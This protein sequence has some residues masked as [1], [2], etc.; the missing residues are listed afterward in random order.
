MKTVWYI[1]ILDNQKKMTTNT[2][3]TQLVRVNNSYCIR[4]KT[5]HF[6]PKIHRTLIL[7]LDYS[8]S[9]IGEPLRCGRQAMAAV[10][11]KVVDEFDDIILIM[12]NNNVTEFVVTKTNVEEVSH[13]VENWQASG[14]TDFTNVFN[15]IIRILQTRQIMYKNA[16][17]L[18][19]SF[20][21]DGKHFAGNTSSYNTT[22]R[23]VERL[24]EMSLLGM[25]E[26]LKILKSTLRNPDILNAGGNT[27]VVTRGYG[28]G[29]DLDLLNQISSAGLTNGD[30]RYASTP[31]EIT[32]IMT[33]D[34][35]L[36]GCKLIGNVNI[37][38]NGKMYTKHM[39]LTEIPRI[40]GMENIYTHEGEI[41]VTLFNPS[42]LSESKI[43][44]ELDNK[45]H[46]VIM[47]EVIPHVSEFVDIAMRYC[48]NEILEVAQ[49][50]VK[51]NANREIVKTSVERLCQLDKYLNTVW[52]VIQK[53]KTRTLRSSLA[54][55]FNTMKEKIHEMNAD[56]AN[57]SRSGYNNDRMSK[58]L[59]SGHATAF[60]TKSGFRNRINKRVDKNMEVLAVEDSK[61]EAVAEAFDETKFNHLEDNAISCFITLSPWYELVKN[62]D[63][64]CMTGFMARSEVAIA[65]PSKIR[66]LNVYPMINNM[67]FSTFQ[68]ELLVKL[69]RNLKHEDQVHGGF[70]FNFKNN[71][72]VVTALS[73]QNINFVYPL[74]IC[75]EHW[76]VAKYLIKRNLGWMATL[77]WAG[78]DFQQMKTIPF[79]IMNNVISAFYRK[80]ATEAVIQKF[81][82][83]ARVAKQVIVDYNMKTVNE[84]FDN[85]VKSPL[86]RTGDV[87]KD[88]HVFL[89]K[90]LFMNK[91]PHLDNS[92]WLS[93]VEELSRRTLLRKARNNEVDAYNITTLASAHN[94]KQYVFLSKKATTNVSRFRLSMV[95]YM[96]DNGVDVSDM[97]N[98]ENDDNSS[99]EVKEIPVFNSNNYSITDVMMKPVKD[100]EMDIQASIEFMLMIKKMYEYL[101]GLEEIKVDLD[102]L[103]DK[104]DANYGIITADHVL[105]F[106]NLEFK[107]IKRD[108]YNIG[109]IFDVPDKHLYA[110][111]LQ[112]NSHTQHSKRRDAVENGSYIMPFNNESH[113]LVQKLVDGAIRAEKTRQMTLL[114]SNINE[115]YGC[116][117]KNTDDILTAAG[118]IYTECKNMGDRSFIYLYKQLQVGSYTPLF[119]EKVRL[120]VE[121]EYKGLRLYRDSGE[122]HSRENPYK[123][124]AS[125]RNMSYIMGAYRTI[126]EN[127]G[128]VYD[129][130]NDDWLSIFRWKS[131]N[132]GRVAQRMAGE[133]PRNK[134]KR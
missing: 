68:D 78:S 40:D 82:N 102:N 130:S 114:Q 52:G 74:Y 1:I 109:E 131:I 25:Y 51:M 111:F 3:F 98:N 41:F 22:S 90:L 85:W 15:A 86:Y 47:E 119:L 23:E 48:G 93:I 123:W 53:I 108:Y 18:R 120:L 54:E 76:D 42:N 32:D 71:S 104:L 44:I 11:R 70:T 103:Y 49:E 125:W 28:S 127:N 59:S 17:D 100:N 24:N 2:S 105:A 8:G 14:A 88:I 124:P 116:L 46:M 73:N 7:T 26:T 64:L 30:Y 36:T 106:S 58:L 35:V 129:M 62:G 9:M 99:D 12:Y 94:Y 38:D 19:V 4:F 60:I 66:F 45:K 43:S 61:I 79:T 33:S 55:W 6:A 96:H 5:V 128:G 72:G 134:N 110:M 132:N 21:T 56:V 67:S 13:R 126:V 107:S 69:D 101:N 115:E 31:N 80:G 75:K 84:D 89:I 95:G 34:S 117:F 63:M 20:F 27:T 92:F 16:V 57:V 97:E 10:L 121:G 87:I 122:Y 77:D 118:I 81:F 39:N 65:D 50:V 29:N 112:N 83:M 133:F 113:V 91:R 37:L